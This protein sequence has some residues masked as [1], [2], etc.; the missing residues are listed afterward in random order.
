[1]A[2]AKKHLAD[3]LTKNVGEF[4]ADPVALLLI[5]G[6][7]LQ[8]GLAKPLA[9]IAEA[10]A[11]EATIGQFDPTLH[12]EISIVSA[13]AHM[14]LGQI[15]IAAKRLS[16]L[17][18]QLGPDAVSSHLL[19]SSY[20]ALRNITRIND[21]VTLFQSAARGQGQWQSHYGAF[22]ALTRSGRLAEADKVTSR[23]ERSKSRENAF[24]IK[25]ALTEFRL[26]KAKKSANVP[27]SYFKPL[28]T[29]MASLYA[30]HPTWPL[31]S[32]LYAEA[33]LKSGQAA[34]AGKVS[35]FVDQ[36]AEARKV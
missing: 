19:G 6:P 14:A 27:V 24:W 32:E 12:R 10:A 4:K 1:M 25:L 35:A 13:R 15:D 2:I 3:A 36:R 16:V 26:A 5:A 17:Q 22:L 8:L 11:A 20:L 31:V 9:V 28:A 33:L 18:K 34:E 7:A 29:D 23:L 30:S 21:A